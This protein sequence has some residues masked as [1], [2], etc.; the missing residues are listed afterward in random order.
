MGLLYSSGGEAAQGQS[1]EVGGWMAGNKNTSDGWRLGEVYWPIIKR[2]GGMN[3][4]WMRTTFMA[5]HL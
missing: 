1:S 5:D 3:G 2:A 4:E